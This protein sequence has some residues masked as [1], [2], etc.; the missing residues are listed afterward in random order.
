MR[1][2]EKI[3]SSWRISEAL[4][5]GLNCWF[6]P[7]TERIAVYRIHPSEQP[8]VE[9]AET[10]LLAERVAA[11]YLDKVVSMSALEGEGEASVQDEHQRVLDLQ[12]PLPF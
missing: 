11:G 8:A 9:R 2:Q 3:V 10:E 5:S 12:D 6:D 1:G 7:L 4:P